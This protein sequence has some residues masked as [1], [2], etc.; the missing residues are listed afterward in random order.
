MLEELA[1]TADDARSAVGRAEGLLSEKAGHLAALREE[2]R[3][4]DLAVGRAEG[5]LREIA[6]TS[7]RSEISQAVLWPSYGEIGEYG[8]IAEIFCRIGGPQSRDS[9]EIGI[10]TGLRNNLASSSKAG[11]VCGSRAR[12][13][14]HRQRLGPFT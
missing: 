10:E 6:R 8:M 2:I 4:G 1:A 13:L 3:S 7:G 11:A 5:L 12:R 9:I 14:S